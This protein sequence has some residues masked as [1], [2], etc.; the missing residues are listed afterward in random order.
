M[1]LILDLI[2]SLKFNSLC[3][4]HI[5]NLLSFIL[6]ALMTADLTMAANSSF[7]FI[8]DESLSK[9]TSLQYYLLNSLLSNEN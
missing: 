4:R 7:F 6:T 3:D 1:A 5:Y 2:I 8:S 9:L